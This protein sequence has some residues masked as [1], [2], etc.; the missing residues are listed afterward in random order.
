MTV[1]NRRTIAV[2]SDSFL[3][4][5]Q[6]LIRS[7][8]EAFVEEHDAN[9]HYIV[10]RQLDTPVFSQY[11]TTN[12]STGEPAPAKVDGIIILSGPLSNYCSHGQ[13]AVFCRQFLPVPMCSIGVA[14]PDIPSIV[15]KNRCF[16]LIVEHL[17]VVHKKT[18]FAFLAGPKSNGE[19]ATRRKAFLKTLKKYDIPFDPQLEASGEFLIH[20]GFEATMQ[21]LST[22]LPFEVLVAA[23]DDMAVGALSA[24]NQ[25]G[26]RVPDDVLV[27]GFDDMCEARF[28]SPRLTTMRQPV[29]EISDLAVSVLLRQMNGQTVPLLTEV[30]P[31]L[32]VRQSCGC[33]LP[34]LQETLHV[35]EVPPPAV[36]DALA[37]QLEAVLLT[38]VNLTGNVY[39]GWA[40]DLVRG[41]LRELDGQS[42][43]LCC[44]MER[45]L[46]SSAPSTRLIDELN[47]AITYLRE[48]LPFSEGRI[49]QTEN[50]WHSARIILFN[51]LARRHMNERLALLRT[52]KILV[53]RT[54]ENSPLTKS[55]NRL[56]E[57]IVHELLTVGV[58][59]AIV[60]IFSDTDTDINYGTLECIV[61]I[62]NAEQVEDAR[63]SYSTRDLIPDFMK[64]DTRQSYVFFALSDG[65]LPLGVLAMDNGGAG[66]YY[67][68][69][70]EYLSTN[71]RLFTLYRDHQ[72]QLRKEVM[73]RQ[74]AMELQHRQ[75]LESLGVLAG[76]IAHDFNNMLSVMAGNLDVV[77]MQLSDGDPYLEPIQECRNTVKRATGLVQQLLA[78]SG[79]GKFSVRRVN[80]NDVISELQDFLKMAVSKNVALYYNLHDNLPDVEADVAQL[81]QIFVNLVLN[82]SE[83]IEEHGR[84]GRIILETTT[85]HLNGPYFLSTITREPMPEGRYVIARVADTGGGID[86]K[87]LAQ[88]F[89]PFYTTKTGG[90]GLGLSAVL[91]IIRT[92]RGA[93]RVESTK[94]AGTLFEIAFPRLPGMSEIPGAVADRPSQLTTMGTVL[95]VDDEKSVLKAGSRL[96]K[97]LGFSTLE[98]QNGQQAIQIME[99]FPDV[100]QCVILDITMPG[101]NGVA[102]MAEIK[103]LSPRTPV[104]LSSGYSEEAAYE[105]YEGVQPA[106]FLKKPYN[107][108]S[109]TRLL[110]QV[111]DTDTG[112]SGNSST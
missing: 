22:R 15:M 12:E 4:E 70:S 62:R 49:V 91:G 88:I 76:G 100:I 73:E 108:E 53:M 84:S 59:N 111:L 46:T 11:A 85:R 48:N 86:D 105:H 89:D 54:Y 45:I 77:H 90:R 19:A 78:Y 112:D 31:R 36:P 94:G 9:L 93:I 72:Q 97:S 98:A 102:A 69:L 34:G 75:K 65:K 16:D 80:L 55:P 30:E 17:I 51:A 52:N 83:A 33:A 40:R 13:M 21:L 60:S 24:L 58:R 44:S 7:S 71:I 56:I 43:E 42:G 81:H 107:L 47:T 39:R 110:Q 26:I 14:I 92:H 32:I 5:Y 25:R 41:L 38:Q 37:L 20:K 101:I 29:E 2:L 35:S 8:V 3:G 96:L 79:K 64:M 23:N 67:E 66:S 99:D 109:L 68:M 6:T 74:K 104:V 87:M 28:A 61:A 95:I 1:P 106:A 27:T 82:A 103:K 18:Q 63:V 10:A 57:E 50:M